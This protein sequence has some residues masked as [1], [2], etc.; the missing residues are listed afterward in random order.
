MLLKN[1][2]WTFVFAALFLIPVVDLFLGSNLPYEYFML[3]RVL[4]VGGLGYLTYLTFEQETEIGG[5]KYFII[6][7]GLTILYNP[8]LP[9]HL[10]R[11]IWTPIDLATGLLILQ[12]SW[13]K[14]GDNFDKPNE[15]VDRNKSHFSS[16]EDDIRHP[17]NS[18]ITNSSVS[19][20]TSETVDRNKSHFSSLE[21]DIRHP[22]SSGITNPSFS[23]LT[24]EQVNTW[25]ENAPETDKIQKTLRVILEPLLMQRDMFIINAQ[26][27]TTYL[28]SDLALGFVG[29][30]V[31]GFLQKVGP[32]LSL[33][34]SDEHLLMGA[35]INIVF[36]NINEN[37][38]R[39]FDLQSENKQSFRN[40]QN[41][42]GQ[43]AF[44]FLNNHQ[45]EPSKMGWYSHF[46]K[47]CG[48]A[49]M[50]ELKPDHLEDEDYSIFDIF[51]SDEPRQR[52]DAQFYME[53][54]A[55]ELSIMFYCAI[56]DMKLDKTDLSQIGYS[57]MML[58]HGS[59]V[60]DSEVKSA[61]I[62]GRP[63]S[64][65]DPRHYN[66]FRLSLKFL[67]L[68]STELHLRKLI[69]YCLKILKDTKSP[70]SKQLE[71]IELLKQVI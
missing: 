42:G 11:G 65:S 60:L 54:Y 23:D 62:S 66:N 63:R 22:P 33:N 53:N 27:G 39:F 20:L 58:S 43:C 29:G 68:N 45:I 32:K 31:D 38:E 67:K 17:S 49:E 12:Y 7:G 10:T 9:V 48:G 16:L 47:W 30:F 6:F 37:P 55:H 18:D 71:I 26:D 3:L 28:K 35:I 56:A 70:T 50:G 59:H 24:S 52:Y 57:L 61:L 34:Q 19:D 13:Q 46:I 8:F 44:K 69:K 2:D 41:T 5:V 40:A 64:Y 51:G 25:K 1:E 21:D 4:A 15:P 36:E 14:T